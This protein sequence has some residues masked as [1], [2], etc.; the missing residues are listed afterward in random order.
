MAIKIII[1][2][3]DSF[4]PQFKSSTVILPGNYVV[5]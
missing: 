4:V 1:K 5:K 3:H 2:I